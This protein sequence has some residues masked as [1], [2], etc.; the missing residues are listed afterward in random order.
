MGKPRR[1]CRYSQKIIEKHN[2]RDL[3][4]GIIQ[5][6]KLKIIACEVLI[7]E[8]SWCVSRTPHMI[9]M[10]FTPKGAHE[11]GELLRETIEK[12]IK[13]TEESG[14]DYDAILLGYGL[15]G[16]GTTGLSSSLYPLIIPR[17]HDCCTLY[18]G[19]RHRFRELFE[20]NPSR[21]YSAAGYAERGDTYL[22]E[23]TVGAALGLNKTY[24]DYVELYGEENARF[25]METIES[26]D[27]N[28][29]RELYYI[30]IPETAHPEL[31]ESCIKQA[32]KEEYQVKVHQGD[33][34]LIRRLLEGD[35]DSEDFLTVPPGRTI[36]PL[37]DWEKI[38]ESS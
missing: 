3:R 15:C 22:H 32:E 30:D 36:T 14:T 37:Y 6:M 27:E 34:G 13:K 10:V 19:S 31:R 24:E 1:M 26:A 12:E 7:R 21:P 5:I 4:R 9:D 11:S 8:I 28:S 33:I 18:L 2:E 23:S 20:D 35:W 29:C 38:I 25:I 17:A 16:N